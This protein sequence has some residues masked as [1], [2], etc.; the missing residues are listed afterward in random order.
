MRAASMSTFGVLTTNGLVA[1][2]TSGTGPAGLVIPEN[3][4][5]SVATFNGFANSG[6]PSE[7]AD[8]FAL[9]DE[10]RVKAII[11]EY[12]PCS[13]QFN[14]IS[15]FVV[16]ADYDNELSAGVLTSTQPAIRYSTARMVSPA[17]ESQFIW[18]APR[19]RAFTDWQS[20]ANTAARG[21]IYAYL[22]SNTSGLTLGTFTVKWL[23]AFRNSNG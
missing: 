11:F 10:F 3:P 20:T 1:V 22:K 12:Q 21:C 4:G 23:V 19:R 8:Y 14:S 6:T 17:F 18:Q 7:W 15:E 16:L 5:R 2:T 13:T 9:Y